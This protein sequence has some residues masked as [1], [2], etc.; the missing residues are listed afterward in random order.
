MVTMV[1]VAVPLVVLQWIL[2]CART[3]FMPSEPLFLQ[4]VHLK[5]FPSVALESINYDCLVHFSIN[6]VHAR[7][8]IF[9]QE[10]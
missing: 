8:S 2:C 4:D 5:K 6:Y 7:S 10:V 9:K 3:I 1:M